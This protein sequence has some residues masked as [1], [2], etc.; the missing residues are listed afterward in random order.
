LGDLL[1][2]PSPF[3]CCSFSGARRIAC[4]LIRRGEQTRF[5][6]PAKDY[7]SGDGLSGQ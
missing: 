6:R 4:E 5:F 3:M 1:R 7:F 2:P